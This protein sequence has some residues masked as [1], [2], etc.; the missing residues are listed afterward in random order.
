MFFAFWIGN[1]WGFWTSSFP[2]TITG[3]LDEERMRKGSQSSTWH[4]NVGAFYAFSFKS[5]EDIR[6]FPHDTFKIRRI[7]ATQGTVGHLV[8]ADFSGEKTTSNNL[9]WKGSEWREQFVS[10]Y[11]VRDLSFEIPQLREIGSAWKEVL[12]SRLS[13]TSTLLSGFSSVVHHYY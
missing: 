1:Q 8:S 6:I 7:L 2:F 9:K 4:S 3:Q 12:S 13:T 10:Q 5:K 11:F